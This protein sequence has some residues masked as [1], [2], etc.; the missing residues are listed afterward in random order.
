MICGEILFIKV[1]MLKV[2]VTSKTHCTRE[3][4]SPLIVCP[5]NIYVGAAT[6]TPLSKTTRAAIATAVSSNAVC[7][8]TQHYPW[9]IAYHSLIRTSISAQQKAVSTH[10]QERPV[11]GFEE[12]AAGPRVVQQDGHITILDP[13]TPKRRD[14]G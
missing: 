14:S 8:Y 10:D 12:A 4:N 9:L 11:R 2:T 13:V 3:R 1:M 5:Q 7:S 6:A